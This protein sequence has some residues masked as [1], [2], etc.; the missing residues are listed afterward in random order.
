MD[1]L[2]H[3]FPLAD[4]ARHGLLAENVLPGL[5]GLHGHDAVPVGR[6]GNVDN[7]HVGVV[8]QV[9]PVRVGLQAGSKLLHAGIQ[10]PAQVIL[11]HV[12]HSHQAATPVAGKVEAAHAYSAGA[13]DAPRKLVAGRHVAVVSAHF[14]QHFPRQNG[15]QANPGRSLF[16]KTSS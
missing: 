10:C 2:H 7:V 3:L 5:G 6:R 8:N 9:A 4:G 1:G 11:V 12:A 14:P 13:Y 15:K 16:D